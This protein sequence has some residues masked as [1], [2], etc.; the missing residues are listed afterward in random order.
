VTALFSVTP[1]DYGTLYREHLLEQ[2]K[3]YVDSADRISQRRSTTNSFLLTVNASLATLYG[4][5]TPLKPTGAAAWH[6]LIPFA[7]ILVCLAWLALVDSY[8]NLNSAK[9]QILHEL[10]TRLPV[11]LYKHEWALL[12]HGK[13]TIYKPVSHIEEWIPVVFILLY[14]GLF[15]YSVLA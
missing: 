5:T 6:L 13:G 15:L 4:L 9:F 8:R 7:G 2:Y 3:L 10:E 11:Y 1:N 14:V 12:E